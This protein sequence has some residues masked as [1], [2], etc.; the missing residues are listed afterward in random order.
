MKFRVLVRQWFE[1]VAE[2][3]VEA[4]TYGAAIIKVE[5]GIADGDI[6]PNWRD[7]DHGACETEA[8]A[9]YDDK[10]LLWSK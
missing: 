5:N 10:Y 3:E 6:D 8:Y 7:G 2:V 9:V 4:A 1:E